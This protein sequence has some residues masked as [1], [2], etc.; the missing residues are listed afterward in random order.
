MI[1]ENN[2]N[3]ST[4]ADIKVDTLSFKIIMN[5]K[6]TTSRVIIPTIGTDIQASIVRVFPKE[7][8]RMRG[9]LL[10]RKGT[11]SSM[12]YAHSSRMLL[13]IEA[14]SVVTFLGPMLG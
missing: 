11:E 6:K 13:K 10:R 12:T 8:F 9:N 2:D 1:E 14:L 5:V 7:K 3:L 4:D